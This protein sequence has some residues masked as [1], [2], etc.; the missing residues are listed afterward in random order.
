MFTRTL[1][2][3]STVL[4]GACTLPAQLSYGRTSNPAP[5]ADKDILA[6]AGF[7]TS[8]G[9]VNGKSSE[10]LYVVTTGVNMRDG[11]AVKFDVVNVLRAKQE[12]VITAEQG[13]WFQVEFRPSPKSQAVSGWVARDFLK[14]KG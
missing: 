14:V 1:F 3:L 12:V 8:A 9:G 13:K 5:S 7:E 2:L 10:K 4:V 6:L 11:P